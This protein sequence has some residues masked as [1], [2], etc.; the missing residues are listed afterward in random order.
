MKTIEEQIILNE[1]DKMDKK[2][3]EYLEADKD[4]E[5]YENQRNFWR[6]VYMLVED[7]YKYRELKAKG[8]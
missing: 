2:I 8:K 1:I 5:K 7:G 6:S 4:A 3:T